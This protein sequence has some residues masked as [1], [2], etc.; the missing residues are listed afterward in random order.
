LL[1]RQ[2]MTRLSLIL[3]LSFVVFAI[4][5]TIY[6]PQDARG[7]VLDNA[8]DQAMDAAATIIATPAGWQFGPN[9]PVKTHD[10]TA[11]AAIETG[12]GGAVAGSDPGLL[13]WLRHTPPHLQNFTEIVP[14]EHGGQILTVALEAAQ[15]DRHFLIA[16]RRPAS[17]GTIALS[18]LADE[19]LTEILPTFVPAMLFALL[20]AWFTIH[21]ALKPLLRASAEVVA[22]S[23]DRP[24]QRVTLT[25]MPGEVTPLIEAVN[26]AFAA[27][28]TALAVQRRFT[29]NAA[30]QMRTPLAVIAARLESMEEGP[31]Q[32]A[33][34]ADVAR[35]TRLLSQLLAVARLEAGQIG[36]LEPLDLAVLARATLADLEPLAEAGNAEFVLEAPAP[37]WIMGSKVALA[38][39][40][41]NLV[42]N[43]L[44]F[45]QAGGT[46][47]VAI[48]P[49]PG[50][51]VRDHGPGIGDSDRDKIFEAF[52]RAPGQSGGGSGLGLAIA[53]DI[54][55]LHG[56]HIEAQNAPGG[57]ALFSVTFPGEVAPPACNT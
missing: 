49:G 43:A 42:E 23:A 48:G 5:Y 44:R 51:A 24:G 29:A 32:A 39:L 8:S 20:V 30:H 37:V 26:N 15:A 45:T 11:I 12:T 13:A 40:L 19:F 1:E 38:Q 36:K 25:G 16:L 18:G 17:T 2:L 53:R 22:V 41:I 27:L 50:F 56:G 28:E 10:R 14:G 9:A 3:A 33:L 57:G 4:F 21:R 7:H 35:L 6:V 55:A 52:W 47:E 34:R 46:V 54:V 31:A